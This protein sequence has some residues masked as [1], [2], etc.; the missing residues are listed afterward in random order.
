[1]EKISEETIVKVSEAII[2]KDG[3]PVMK[4][5]VNDTV[6]QSGLDL[7]RQDIKARYIAA[8][9]ADIQVDLKYKEIGRR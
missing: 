7:Y 8:F 9:A 6:A 1:M 2:I 5:I 4:F 3:K